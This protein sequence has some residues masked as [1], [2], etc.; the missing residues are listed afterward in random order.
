MRNGSFARSL[1]AEGPPAGVRFA[2]QLFSKRGLPER[3]HVGAV[4]WFIPWVLRGGEDGPYMALYA[5]PP[6]ADRMPDL[7]LSVGE[8]DVAHLPR[9]G[10]AVV[11]GDVAPLGALG[12]LVGDEIVWPTYPPRQGRHYDPSGP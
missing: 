5:D 6:R 11:F 1:V 12:V 2:Y 3:G 10:H 4:I 8:H 7:V 9:S